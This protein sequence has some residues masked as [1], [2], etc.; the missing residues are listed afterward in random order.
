MD[1]GGQVG[2]ENR[3]KIDPKRHRKNDGKKKGTRITK[4]SKKKLTPPRDPSVP[5][6]R[7]GGNYPAL[8]SEVV[9]LFFSVFFSSEIYEIVIWSV[10]GLSVELRS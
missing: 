10:S 4:K 3:S 9:S 2:A 7:G 8:L 1:F 6:P 5:D